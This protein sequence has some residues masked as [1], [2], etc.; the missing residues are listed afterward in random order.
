MIDGKNDWLSGWVDTLDSVRTKPL[1]FSH[2]GNESG[3]LALRSRMQRST[4]E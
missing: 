2:V 1:I 4:L 3:K